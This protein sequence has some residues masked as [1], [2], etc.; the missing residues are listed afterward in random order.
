MNKSPLVPD[1]FVPV[2]EALDAAAALARDG[3]LSGANEW[4]QYAMFELGV[5]KG[6]VPAT[7]RDEWQKSFSKM[8]GRCFTAVR[9]GDID[10]SLKRVRYIMIALKDSPPP[11]NLS[12]V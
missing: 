11:F 4:M 5:V 3:D 6:Q 10:R 8:I 12:G 2:Y 9:E 7:A 1:V